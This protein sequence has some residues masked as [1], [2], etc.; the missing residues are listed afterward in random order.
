MSGVNPSD[1]DLIA[2]ARAG[3]KAAFGALAERHLP[4]ARQTALY[5]LGDADLAW[6]CAQ[7]AV[8]QAYLGLETLHDPERFPAWLKGITR[9]ICRS[10]LRRH[11]RNDYTFTDWFSSGES[12]TTYHMDADLDPYQ[13]VEERELHGLLQGAIDSL[14]PKN[15]I[16][17]LLFYYE[18]LSI[19]EI[20]AQ[21]GA[22]VTAIKGRLYQ[23]RKQMQGQLAPV[24][25][26]HQLSYPVRGPTSKRSSVMIKINTL[27]AIPDEASQHAVIYLLDT[28][29]GRMLR[30]WIGAFEGE[31]IY[32]TLHGLPTVRPT[33]YRFFANILTKIGGTIEAVHID[34]LKDI[35]YY[36]TVKV[37]NGK[38]TYEV[39]ARPS[40][41][42][43]LAL[44][45]NSAIFVSEALMAQAGS[46]LPQPFEE[47]RW[48]QEE[49]R[50]LAAAGMMTQ[51]WQQKLEDE[52]TL[53][54]TDA[55]QL[56][57][58]M[59]QIAQSYNHNY[60]GTEHLLLGLVQDTT[61]ETAQ[62]L[63][64]FGVNSER[65]SAAIVRLIGH[66]VT[67]TADEPRMAPRVGHVLAFASAQAQSAGQTAI[68]N[69]HLL[70]ALIQEGQG[71]AIKILRD[72]GVE[73]FTLWRKL[74]EQTP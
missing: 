60:I 66:S 58:Q 63:A 36:A 19:E 9:N 73:P 64:S 52:P 35:T 29:G 32:Q 72:L 12:A 13:L 4:T 59:R 8:L 68:N 37:G 1:K 17:L 43:A 18:Q 11:K 65:V 26:P 5:M 34:L 44:Q 42:I 10:Y 25:A 49:T 16:A 20:A 33:A 27:H 53:F 48:R 50:R 40:D 14:S 38:Q 67:P 30:I 2:A 45:T 39:D 22:S 71:M 21:L 6:E 28:A 7:E 62:L 54:A 57:R 56:L 3:D 15:R 69:R 31:Q 55:Q 46:D 51:S 47:Q 74:T 61:T 23:A 24:Y 41:A 70:A